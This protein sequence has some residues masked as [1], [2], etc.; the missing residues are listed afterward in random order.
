MQYKIPQNVRREDQ[1]V[2]PLTLRQLAICGIGGGLGY[3]VYV[4]LARSYPLI[5]S[6]TPAVLIGLLT[7]A[8]AFLK[9]NG[10]PFHQ[11]V[12]LAAEYWFLPRQRTFI[13][14]AADLYSVTVFSHKE[15]VA[16]AKKAAIVPEVELTNKQKTKKI[17]EISKFLDSYSKPTL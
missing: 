11:W 6:L 9:I 13:L 8:L 1:I 17:G 16:N 10:I 3:A 14:G 15:D 12:F 2:G 4:V 5:V 7:V